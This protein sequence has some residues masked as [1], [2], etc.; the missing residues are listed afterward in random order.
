MSDD[1]GCYAGNCEGRDLPAAVELGRTIMEGG[2]ARGYRG[3]A[4]FDMAVTS[5]RMLFVF[6][7]N[8]RT[9][10]ST[11]A[12]LL[13][14]SLEERLGPQVVRLRSWSTTMA[15]GRVA[16]VVSASV[17]DCVLIPLCIHHHAGAATRTSVTRLM[18]MVLGA[19]RSEVGAREARLRAALS[20]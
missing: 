12:L 19:S 7:L 16:D 8:F 17:A 14:R 2:V 4:G 15:F 3:F 1:N 11:V 20:G 9:N 13:L 18:G 10:G 5:E 6:D